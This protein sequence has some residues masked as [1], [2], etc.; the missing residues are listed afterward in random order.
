MV[1]IYD[2]ANYPAR[3]M[4][5]ENPCKILSGHTWYTVE[6]WHV[7]HLEDNGDLKNLNKCEVYL[8]LNSLVRIGVKVTEILGA[9][10]IYNTHLSFL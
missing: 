10:I 1:K 9:G 7:E 3:D 4:L 6:T 8:L 2:M 5:R